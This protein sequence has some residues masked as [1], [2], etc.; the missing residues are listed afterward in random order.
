[1]SLPNYVIFGKRKIDHGERILKSTYTG[2]WG[3]M[4][5]FL[6]SFGN[7]LV[8]LW[9]R[10]F[11]VIS[12]IFGR[13]YTGWLPYMKCILLFFGQFQVVFGNS[14]YFWEYI[15]R[16]WLRNMKCL[17]CHYYLPAAPFNYPYVDI[18]GWIYSH[19]QMILKSI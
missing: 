13:T 6:L 8:V 2:W 3:N 1:M 9:R 11:L 16:E 17:L 12:C 10:F 5:C 19:Y 15:H 4:K 7:V 18:I 14:W